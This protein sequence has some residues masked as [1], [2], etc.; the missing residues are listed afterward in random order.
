MPE[1]A[2]VEFFRRRW[3]AGH[4]DVVRVHASDELSPG[5]GDCPIICGSLPSVRLVNHADS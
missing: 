5:F 2:E 1:L 3:A 4:G